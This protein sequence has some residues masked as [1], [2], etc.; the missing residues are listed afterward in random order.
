[1]LWLGFLH[2]PLLEQKKSLLTP[3]NT[4]KESRTLPA[5]GKFK[6]PPGVF[7]WVFPIHCQSDTCSGAVQI[8]HTWPLPLLVAFLHWRCEEVWPIV[9]GTWWVS[10]KSCHCSPSKKKLFAKDLK[11]F[12]AVKCFLFS[13][14]MLDLCMA[15]LKCFDGN[16]VAQKPV[17]F[18]YRGFHAWGIPKNACFIR[19]NPN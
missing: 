15:C 9:M 11:G 5:L 10:E 1:M 7:P 6:P 2:L 14:R 8:L 16:Q 19:E 13:R 17:G 4:T 12:C 3:N 18:S